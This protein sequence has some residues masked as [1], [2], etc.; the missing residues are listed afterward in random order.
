M[1]PDCYS[2][3]SHCSWKR[4]V[5]FDI[6]TISDK[7]LIPFLKDPAPDKRLKNE[8]K[9]AEQ[10]AEKKAAQIADMAKKP[11]YNKVICAGF[12]DGIS[13]K[14]IVL[15][16]GDDEKMFLQNIWDILEE[17]DYYI[18]FNGRSFDFP[19]LLMNSIRYQVKPTVR[20]GLEMYRV[21]NHLDLRMILGFWDKYAEGTLDFFMRAFGISGGKKGVD[22][23][24]IA[25][26]YANKQYDVIADYCANGDCIDTWNLWKYVK[27]YS[28][29]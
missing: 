13:S 16:H 2:Q 25:D 5:A 15:K 10:I 21:S 19:A 24:M 26:L 28:I 23:S 6:E 22:G 1:K 9:I 17:Y 29:F 8:D 18:T 11:L 4:S 14:A 12:Y 3:K 27:E 20:V 7:N